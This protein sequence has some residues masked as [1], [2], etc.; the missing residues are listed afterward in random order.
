MSTH[1]PAGVAQQRLVTSKAARQAKAVQQSLDESMVQ[2]SF[3]EENSS[4]S[5]VIQLPRA[6]VDTPWWMAVQ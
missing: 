5:F 6:P 2:V 3:T 1:D 4:F